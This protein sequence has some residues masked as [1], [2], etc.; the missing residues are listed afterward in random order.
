[1]SWTPG[2]TIVYRHRSLDGRYLGGFPL[3]VL[4]D[5]ADQL[6]AYLPTGTEISRPAHED[7]SD[8]R[9]VPLAERWAWPRIAKRSPFTLAGTGSPGRL[10]IVFPRGRAHSLWIFRAPDRVLGW[11]VNLEDPYVRGERTVST[12]DHLLDIWVPAETA[13]PLWKDE[14]ELEMSI[15]LGLRSRQ[16]GDAI[17]AEGERVMRER[18]W[19]TGFEDV[20]PDPSWAAPALF[21]GWDVP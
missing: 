15:A 14:D 12:R 1:M 20:E 3:T 16:Q 21:D 11:Y 10:V 7:G 5:R 2:T 18:P 8:L 9:S 17:R 6:A 4:D 19:P 13:E